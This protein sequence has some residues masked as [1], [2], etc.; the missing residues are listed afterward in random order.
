MSAIIDSLADRFL[1]FYQMYS[2]NL[3]KNFHFNHALFYSFI[4]F[5]NPVTFVG[6]WS[7]RWRRFRRRSRFRS[8]GR[9]KGKEK[10]KETGGRERKGE[11]EIFF[12]F[13]F[14]LHSWKTRPSSWQTGW[15]RR[16]VSVFDHLHLF[17]FI[18]ILG[19]IDE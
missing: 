16:R 2:S 17:T 14:F 10:T 6:W 7:W 12:F 15:R 1:Y 11:R 8:R 9:R 3:D 5:L 18:C 13:F 4:T 19:V